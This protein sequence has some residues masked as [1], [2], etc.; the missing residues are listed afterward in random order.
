MRLVQ[1]ISSNVTSSRTG[2]PAAVEASQTLTVTPRNV[3][4]PPVDMPYMEPYLTAEDDPRNHTEEH[5]GLWYNISREEFKRIFH[6]FSL[7]IE[8]NQLCETFNETSFMIRRPAL[9]VM[10]YL[11][12]LNLS[13]M[14]PPRFMFYGAQGTGKTCSIAHVVHFLSRENFVILQVPW[15]DRWLKQFLKKPAEILPSAKNPQVWDHTTDASDWLKFFST[16]NNEMLKKLQL[17][18]FDQYQFSTRE[19]FP[20]GSD[21]TKIVELGISRPRLAAQVVV[22]I[23]LEMKKHASQGNCKVAVVLDGINSAFTEESIYKIDHVDFYTKE[24][25]KYIPA[26]SFTLVQAF[27]NMLEKDWTNGV[28]IGSIDYCCRK[29][30]DKSTYNPRYILGQEGWEALDPFVPVPVP[31]YSPEEFESAFAYLASKHWIQKH[32]ALTPDGRALIA[33]LSERNPDYLLRICA[34]L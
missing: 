17:K 6:P 19:N 18:S 11:K 15:V 25:W 31:E 4:A 28:I 16:Q 3:G 24:T 1:N 29:D 23:T 10:K 34:P 8:Y 30:K 27:T 2:S 21:I 12:Q 20:A 22:A 13:S 33:A 5:L 14:T 9:S 32:E 7:N 26:Q